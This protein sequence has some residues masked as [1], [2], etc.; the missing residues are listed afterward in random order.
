MYA[1]LDDFKQRLKDHYEA[2]YSDGENV[3]DESL[4]LDDL[5]TAYGIVNAFIAAR[6]QTPVTQADALPMLRACQL[7]IAS[8]LAWLRPD[9][10]EL[11]EKIKDAA[12]TA[13][14]QLK[15]IS[16]GAITLPAAPLENASAAGA[17]VI[18]SGDKPVF[19]RSNMGGF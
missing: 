2:I 18:V 14:D 11:P 3:V 13:R 8:E 15:D 1:T 10:N 9:N 7:A 6:Y 17:S 12:K 4:I 19:G 16:K 5:T